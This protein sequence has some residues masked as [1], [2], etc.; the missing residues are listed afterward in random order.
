MSKT[1]KNPP[2]CDGTHTAVRF[3]GKE[4]ASRA[5]YIEQAGQIT[6]PDLVLTDFESLCALA[7][8]C[9]RGGDVWNLT[10]RSDDPKLR[11]TAIEEACNCPSGRLVVCDKKTGKPI[12]PKLK[13]SISLVEDPQSR[14]SGPIWLKGGVPVESSDGTKY[15]V[16]N[17]VTL[18]RCGKSKNKPF[19]DGS[20]IKEGF[21]DGDE[22]L[23]K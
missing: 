14:V 20:H 13:K 15:E 7:R 12:E 4:T 2:Y 18:C 19:C 10:E 1:T 5:P 21:S 22:S 8:F 23:K 9:H 16:R 11:K 17:R 6:G 3:K